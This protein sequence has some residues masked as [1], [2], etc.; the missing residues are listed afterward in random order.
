[1]YIQARSN[2][3][4]ISDPEKI[5][6]GNF[7]IANYRE[8]RFYMRFDSRIEQQTIRKIDTFYTI[9]EQGIRTEFPPDFWEQ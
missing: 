4:C 7:E 1:M 9:P 2:L 8:Y 5:V 6:L 3:K